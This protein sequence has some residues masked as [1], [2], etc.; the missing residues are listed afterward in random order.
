M[1]EM[2]YRP[3]QRVRVT[4]QIPRQSGTSSITVEG[5][6]LRAGQQKTGS[7]FAHSKDDR[8]WLDRLEIRKD[9]GERIVMNLDQYSSVEVLSDG[10]P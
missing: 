8:L 7:W 4:Q 10:S 2:T 1:L 9:D 6:V 3:G 5:I